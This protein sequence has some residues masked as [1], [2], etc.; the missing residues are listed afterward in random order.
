[1]TGIHG[2]GLRHVTRGAV[3][4]AVMGP[5]VTSDTRGLRSI[6]VRMRLVASAAP[7]RVARRAFAAA[8]RQPFYMAGHAEILRGIPNEVRGVIGNPVAC[9][10][11]DEAPAG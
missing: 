11:I 6:R 4:V 2:S 8:G 7:Q 1:M 10:E 3:R 5:L 9:V